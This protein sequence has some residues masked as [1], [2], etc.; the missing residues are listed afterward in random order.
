MQLIRIGAVA[1]LRRRKLSQALGRVRL[2]AILDHA[3][4]HGWEVGWMQGNQIA[5]ISQNLLG[6]GVMTCLQTRQSM[7]PLLMD[8]HT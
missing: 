2:D 8:Q 7:G 3:H 4:L 1:R 6:L 5:P